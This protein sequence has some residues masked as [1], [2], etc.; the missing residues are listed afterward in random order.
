MLKILPL[1]C[2][3][4]KSLQYCKGVIVNKLLLYKYINKMEGQCFLFSTLARLCHFF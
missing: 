3:V 4:L 2:Q 1:F